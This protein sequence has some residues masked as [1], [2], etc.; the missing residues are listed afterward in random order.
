[1]YIDCNRI[2]IGYNF[3]TYQ[4]NCDGV[5]L[6]AGS[7]HYYL[8]YN[9]LLILNRLMGH[10]GSR[11]FLDPL[12]Y[13]IG[14]NFKIPL[15]LFCVNCKNKYCIL[16]PDHTNIHYE[17]AEAKEC[18]DPYSIRF[19][20]SFPWKILGTNACCIEGSKNIRIFKFM[21]DKE[22]VFLLFQFDSLQKFVK[23]KENGITYLDSDQTANSHGNYQVHISRILLDDTPITPSKYLIIRTNGIAF[24]I[25]GLKGQTLKSY[26]DFRKCILQRKN[27]TCR[28]SNKSISKLRITLTTSCQQGFSESSHGSIWNL[29]L[30]KTVE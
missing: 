1:M 21:L 18:Y 3:H 25:I 29:L 10:H 2:P 14:I 27:P 11:V 19:Q 26:D 5:C 13:N 23:T 17:P 24:A 22:D 28:L 8:N 9:I 4:F 6:I 12:N 7:S 30:R 20:N 15:S 16:D